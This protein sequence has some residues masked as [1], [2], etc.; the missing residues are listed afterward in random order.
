MIR[1]CCTAYVAC[2]PICDLPECPREVGYRGRS[3]LV[4]LKRSLA[5][6]DP[7]RTLV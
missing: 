5:G 2:W 7:E 4:L 3:G 6:V 1:R